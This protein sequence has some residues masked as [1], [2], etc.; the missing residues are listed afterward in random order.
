MTT[1]SITTTPGALAIEAIKVMEH[2]SNKA[3]SILTALN[4]DQQFQGPLRLRDLVQ[5]GLA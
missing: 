1:D 4:K 5:R 2:D 3:I